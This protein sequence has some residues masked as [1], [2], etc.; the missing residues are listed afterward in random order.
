MT[1]RL[2]WHACADAGAL[3]RR[4]RELILAQAA[5]AIAAHGCFRLVLAG[6]STPR[7]T[8]RLLRDA[9][10]DWAAW[11]LYFGDERCLPADDEQRNSRMARDA[12]LDQV[13]IPP[14]QIHEIAAEQGAHAGAAAYARVL[15]DVDWFDCVLLGLGEDGH[16]ASLFPGRDHGTGAGAADVLAVLDAPKPPPQRISLSA[17]RLSRTRA[18]WFLVAGS[19][20]RRAV[21]QWRA[22]APIPAASIAPVAGADVLIEAALLEP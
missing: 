13:P 22:G 12:W 15:R 16:T 2:R 21:Q 5:A 10:T 17:A 7:A 18:L 14:S 3:A 9:R 6:G 20:K 1:Q 8:Y 4:A 11:Q 19:S